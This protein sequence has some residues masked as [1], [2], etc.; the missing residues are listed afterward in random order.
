MTHNER[1]KFEDM[2]YN[3]HRYIVY[4]TEYSIRKGQ[5]SPNRGHSS[6]STYSHNGDFYDAKNKYKY[7]CDQIAE[8]ITD[9]IGEQRDL[10]NNW[11]YITDELQ[12]SN[13]IL[14]EIR[15][16]KYFRE[17]RPNDAIT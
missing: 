14:K 1:E 5:L 7:W 17:R 9:Y 3:L 12:V 6:F 10:G 2:R 11:K 15:S 16:N 13:T 4:R 8:L